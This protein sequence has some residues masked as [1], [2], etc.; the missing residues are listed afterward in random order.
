MINSDKSN[1][2]NNPWKR[3]KSKYILK[4]IFDNLNRSKSL[5]II[6]Y[7]K[8]MKSSLK[9]SKRD[10][11]REYSKIVIEVIPKKD[12]Y[13]TF[14][15]FKPRNKP[16]Y[17]IYFNN[18]MN[19]EIKRTYIEKNDNVSKIKII[20]DNNVKS[21]SKLFKICHF[22]KSINFTKFGNKRINNMSYM[23]YGCTSLED[24]NISK[25][26]TDNVTN[27]NNMFRVCSSLKKLDLSSFNTNNV[28]N[29][30]YM[31]FMCSKIKELDLSSFK[32]DN[33]IDMGG[34]FSHCQIK[35]LDISNFGENKNICYYSIFHDLKLFSPN[36]KIK[37]SDEL[38]KIMKSVKKY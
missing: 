7:N 37:C 32:T 8:A 1:L 30:R 22:I 3:I 35:L 2:L 9:I 36:I 28:E 31:F 16:Y 13:G 29:M 21:L 19:K 10:Y 26:I 17:H 20:I 4:Q 25:L 38:E 14:I 12:I 24:L 33:I 11:K 23:F 27:M 15:H 34:I 6:R 18:N 5:N